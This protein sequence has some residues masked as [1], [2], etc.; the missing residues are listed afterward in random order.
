MR[1]GK[2]REIYL[3]IYFFFFSMSGYCKGI[4]Q[5]CNFAN[6]AVREILNIWL[7]SENCKGIFKIADS[8]PVSE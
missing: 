1:Q 2:V 5:I 6:F 4:L 3:F 8:S 7:M